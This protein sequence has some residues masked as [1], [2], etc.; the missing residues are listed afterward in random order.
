MALRKRLKLL[1]NHE[2]MPRDCVHEWGIYDTT[3]TGDLEC[4]EEDLDLAKTLFANRAI[5]WY[6]VVEETLD[7]EKPDLTVVVVES[8][9]H[10][11]I[12][13]LEFNL[14]AKGNPQLV[15]KPIKFEV[16]W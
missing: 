8:A 11:E 3:Q 16:D 1:S 13:P 9:A 10:E 14:K 5:K 15:I 7:L 6:M 2:H 4:Y 12:P